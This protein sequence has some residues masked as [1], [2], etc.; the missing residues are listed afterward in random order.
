MSVDVPSAGLAE[1]E[2]ELREYLPSEASDDFK[3]LLLKELPRFYDEVDESFPDSILSNAGSGRDPFGY[4]TT[5]KQIFASYIDG[6]CAGFTV[7]TMKRGG[8]AKI[9][10]TAV[11]PEF[12]RR[13]V[14]TRLRDAVEAKLFQ[15]YGVRKIYM[16]VSTL[17]GPALMFNLKRGFQTE[18]VLRE[19]YREGGDEIVLGA[20][21]PRHTARSRYAADALT[22]SFTAGGS[23]QAALW[24]DPSLDEL[25]AFLAPRIEPYFDGIERGF[26]ESIIAACQESRQRYD[27]KGKRLV[28]SRA[29]GELTA[30]A[31]YVPKRG[32]S[33]KLSPCIADSEAAA[34][35]LI[36]TCVSVARSEGRRKIYVHLP[37]AMLEFASL[38]GAMGFA[39]E[40]QMR[41]AYKPGMN[42]LVLGQVLA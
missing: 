26:Y 14:A 3:Q 37:D 13:G 42:M 33:V 39:V 16:T 24:N 2:F 41:E 30:A 18:G 17:N 25:Q 10:P 36:D 40:A 31:V 34:R 28:V 12:R 6:Q 5:G 9:G 19:Q 23:D 27:Q 8:S 21:N 32:G 1:R 22:P 29:D 38:L 7:V 20:L 4:F 35:A 11:F 15:D